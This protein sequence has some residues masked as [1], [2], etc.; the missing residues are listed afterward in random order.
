[1]LKVFDDSDYRPDMIKVYP[2]T[3]IKSSEL[4]E[5]LKRGEYKTYSDRHLINML[6]KFKARVPRY[7]RISRL[8]RDIPN[9]HIQAGNTMTNLRQVI[10]EEM[11]KE[12]LKCKC[13]RCRE[14][15]H[16][17]AESKVQSLK[18]KV[19]LFVDEYEAS[20]G[21]EYFLSFEDAGRDVVYAFCRLRILSLRGE[22]RR[23][24]PMGSPRPFGARDD[25]QTAYPAFIRELH[26]YGQLIN[27]GKKSKGASQHVGMG[28]KL[29]AEAEKICKKSKAYQL[30]VISGIGV[31]EYY[32]KFGY[33]L[34]NT[35]MVKNLK[36]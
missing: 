21:K 16:Q 9:H 6:K 14:V 28:T 35:Y 25:N 19:K 8:I 7:I 34:E 12:G 3:V 31:R 4:Y 11:K 1:M 5:W 17:H 30:A 10:Q 32:K 15:G 27:I 29:I 18:S 24:N 23:S 20:G 36:R 33:R 2:C 13:L 26:T 22:K